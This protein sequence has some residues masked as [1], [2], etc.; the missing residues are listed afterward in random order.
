MMDYE[1]KIIKKETS[2]PFSN[3][4]I[5]ERDREKRDLEWQAVE[6]L[7]AAAKK[8]YLDGKVPM[9]NI[10]A[11]TIEVLYNEREKRLEFERNYD[12]SEEL[13]KKDLEERHT[14]EISKAEQQGT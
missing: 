12:P 1:I 9:E 5:V 14:E 8:T 10:L 7:I 3:G 4:L 13:I 11:Q 6:E 2:D